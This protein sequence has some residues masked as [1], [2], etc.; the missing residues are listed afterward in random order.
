MSDRAR[1][2]RPAWGVAKNLND[3]LV[4]RKAMSTSEAV[5]AILQRPAFCRDFK[6]KDQLSRSSTRVGPLIAEGF[7]QLTDRHLA[8]YLGR[9]RGSVLE[10]IGHLEESRAKVYISTSE[11]SDFAEMYDHIGRM[12]TRWIN[13]LQ[14]S[15]WNDRG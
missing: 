9:A 11:Y 14:D 3:V 4:Y 1:N 13:Y 12:L 5:S 15:D 8:T 10:T 2:M 7:G 6:L